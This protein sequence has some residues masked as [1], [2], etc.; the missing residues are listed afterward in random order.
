MKKKMFSI[1]T[2]TKELLSI[3]DIPQNK[4]FYDNNYGEYFAGVFDD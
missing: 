2:C 1:D 3:Y 4:Q